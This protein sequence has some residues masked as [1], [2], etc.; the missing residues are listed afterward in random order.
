MR[1]FCLIAERNAAQVLW[2]ILLR[3][4]SV[5]RNALVGT[6][7]GRFIRHG[8]GID[9]VIL[10]VDFGARAKEGA[11]PILP[12]ET[13]INEGILP[14]RS[15]NV[16]ILTAALVERKSA[17]GNSERHKSIVVLSSA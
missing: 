4:E 15:S 16:C 11:S 14:R 8:V 1:R 17:H 5:E 12:S 7:A 10:H 2:I 9:A 6:D 3:I 13:W